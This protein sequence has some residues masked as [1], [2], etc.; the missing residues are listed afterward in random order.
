MVLIPTAGNLKVV[1]IL[2]YKLNELRSYNRK[3]FLC[4]PQKYV[5]TQPAF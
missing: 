1:F 4:L 5:Q 3:L 2:S